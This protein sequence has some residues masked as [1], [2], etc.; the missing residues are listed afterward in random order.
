[1]KATNKSFTRG[2]VNGYFRVS[3]DWYISLFSNVKTSFSFNRICTCADYIC[4]IGGFGLEIGKMMLDGIAKVTPT[5]IMI[6]FSILYFG[7]MIDRGLFDPMISRLI[8][9]AKGDPLKIVMATSFIT[10]V[11]ALDGDESATFMITVTAL[12][13]IYRGWA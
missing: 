9:F 12:L 13:P 10:L 8:R 11:V 5:S 2:Y 3:D 7:L 6:G 1:M 4:T